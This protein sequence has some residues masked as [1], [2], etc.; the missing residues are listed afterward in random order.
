MLSG[1]MFISSIERS[2]WIVKDEVVHIEYMVRISD[3][4]QL[5]N[6][7]NSITNDVNA[8]YYNGQKIEYNSGTNRDSVERRPTD[9]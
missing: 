6:R 8:M 3:M 7:R 4:Y 2:I 9:E 1:V 5:M